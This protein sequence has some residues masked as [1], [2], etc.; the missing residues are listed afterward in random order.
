M[1]RPGEDRE[2]M[3]PPIVPLSS[4]TVDDK[5]EGTCMF[6]SFTSLFWGPAWSLLNIYYTL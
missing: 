4:T 5:E 3:P 6:F 2:L 1:K